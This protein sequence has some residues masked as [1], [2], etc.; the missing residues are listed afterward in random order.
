MRVFHTKSQA[1]PHDF[2][3]TLDK[4]KFVEENKI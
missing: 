2:V 4:R 1:S 3:W